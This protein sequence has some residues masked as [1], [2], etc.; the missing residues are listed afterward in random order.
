M[1]QL[2]FAF[3]ATQG[4]LG[5]DWGRVSRDRRDI[6][7]GGWVG[8]VAAAP[9]IATI[10]LLIVAG[11]IG[12]TPQTAP[13]PATLSPSPAGS[14]PAPARQGA[15]TGGSA[16]SIPDD[17][18]RFSVVNVL[19][20]GLGGVAGGTLLIILSLGL[21]GPACYT[22]HLIARFAS[23]VIAGPPRWCWSLLGAVATWPLLLVRAPARL[24]LMFDA[25]GALGAP[26][27]GAL[28][29]DRLRRRG[30]W[31]GP[32]PGINPPGALAWLAGL[33]A[34]ALPWIAPRI[35]LPAG[36]SIAVPAVLAYLTAFAV[37]WLCAL[38]GLERAPLTG[39][40]EARQPRATEVAT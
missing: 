25:L 27:A 29:A 23:G 11:A 26:L 22:P 40:P 38:A 14:A 6:Q 30:A 10:A 20:H 12:K 5:I 37:Y 24:D 9:V 7:A 13:A 2:I 21:L 19:Q 15:L 35:G 33:I 18:R 1:V 16:A 28:C 32:R 31:R 8:I 34:G 4:V 36:R 39:E 3:F 17:W